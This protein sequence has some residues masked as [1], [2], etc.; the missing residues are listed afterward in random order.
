MRRVGDAGAD[1]A[2]LSL[3][4]ARG[5]R[6]MRGKELRVQPVFWQQSQRRLVHKRRSRGPSLWACFGA[7]LKAAYPSGRRGAKSSLPQRSCIICIHLLPSILCVQTSG[8]QL[9]LAQL[10]TLRPHLALGMIRHRLSCA[11]CVRVH[12]CAS[13][14]VV[15]PLFHCCCLG[16]VWD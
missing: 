1:M 4:S 9:L 5:T 16:L 12:A 3:A 8:S 7:I 14:V 13:A 11:A 10:N 15:N 6:D 2:R